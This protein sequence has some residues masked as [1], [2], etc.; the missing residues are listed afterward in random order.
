MGMEAGLAKSWV[1]VAVLVTPV[2]KLA[3]LFVI[4]LLIAV[5]F[6]MLSF[7]GCVVVDTQP[8]LFAG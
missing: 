2:L 5:V 3:M 6:I 8:I 1:E 4:G 7:R